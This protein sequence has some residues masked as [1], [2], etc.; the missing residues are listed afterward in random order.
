MDKP[1]QKA[2]RRT[3]ASVQIRARQLRREQT[4]AEAKLWS[5][6][7]NRQ[8]DGF[9]F[10]RQHPI[11]RFVVDF[12]CVD[13]R[14]IVEVDGEVHRSQAAE[15]QARAEA[16]QAAG[17]TIARWTNDQIEHQVADVLAEL[18]RLLNDSPSPAAAGEGARG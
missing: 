9:K 11:G 8:L 5:Y 18:R 6:L 2:R 4:D 1:D 16:L 17:Y 13:R 14:L 10:R 12:C 15:D 3:P 7:R